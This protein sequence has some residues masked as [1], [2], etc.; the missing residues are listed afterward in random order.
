L[1]FHFSEQEVINAMKCGMLIGAAIILLVA[2]GCGVDTWNGPTYSISVTDASFSSDVLSSDKPVL[3]DFWAPWCG[4]CLQL[5]PDLEA[6]AGD[7]QDRLVVARVNVDDNKQ[8]ARQYGIESIPTLIVFHQGK[9][10]GRK[11]GALPKDALENWVTSVL[12]K[13]KEPAVDHATRPTS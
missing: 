13:K 1:R 4:P 6:L 3:V 10:V 2:G 5:A 12:P 11:T 7:L 8:L 9:V